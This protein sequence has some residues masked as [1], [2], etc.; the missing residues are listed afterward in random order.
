MPLRGHIQYVN[1]PRSMKKELRP[2]VKS[3]LQETI[4]FWHSRYLREHFKT[5]AV[6][7]YRYDKRSANYQKRKARVKGHQKPLVWSGELEKKSKR[8][9]RLGGTSKRATGTMDVPPYTYKYHANQPHKAAELTA[10]TDK[11]IRNM[12]GYMQAKLV[13]K[14]NRLKTKET[15]RF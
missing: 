14:L 8:A 11:E 5:S 15:R 9:I 12:A 6:S 4:S 3:E 2:A 1:S 13:R 7:K 10:V